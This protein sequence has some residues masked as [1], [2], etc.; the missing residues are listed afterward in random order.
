MQP[1]FLKLVNN[2]SVVLSS[3]V[4]GLYEENYKF[5]LKDIIQNLKGTHHLLDE[6]A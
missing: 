4:T 1:H 2:S 5:V 6:K 3:K